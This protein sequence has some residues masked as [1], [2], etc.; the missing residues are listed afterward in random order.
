MEDICDKG[1][2]FTASGSITDRNN[3]YVKLL[4]QG[5]Q[6]FLGL[7]DLIWF[8]RD[9]RIDNLGC[10]HFACLIDNR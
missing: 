10:K 1:L 4:D 7:L 6:I 5:G 2:T 3:L 9:N 8:C